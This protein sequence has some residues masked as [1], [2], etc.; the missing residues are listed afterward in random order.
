MSEP[1]WVGVSVVGQI[2]IVDPCRPSV[3]LQNVWVKPGR[4][5]LGE[6]HGDAAHVLGVQS[7]IHLRHEKYYTCVIKH[8][9]KCKYSP[10]ELSLILKSSYKNKSRP[11]YSILSSERQSWVQE[12]RGRFTLK[13]ICD[14]TVFSLMF[15]FFLSL[16]ICSFQCGGNGPSR[17]E[18]NSRQ[19]KG[20]GRAWSHT[21]LW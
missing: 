1:L 19:H 9:D 3:S 8:A 14:I 5:L 21:P 13:T 16:L 18:H 4:E 7:D 12:N 17:A 15:S 11:D 2:L 6:N 10:M 20:K